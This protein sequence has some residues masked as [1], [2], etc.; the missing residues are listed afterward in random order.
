M[1]VETLKLCTEN[2]LKFKLIRERKDLKKYL[3]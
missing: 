3:K 2:R 1:L